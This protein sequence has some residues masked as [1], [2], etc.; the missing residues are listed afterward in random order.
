V[1]PIMVRKFTI[2]GR[3]AYSWMFPN[4]REIDPE[5][6][7][8]DDFSDMERIARESAARTPGKKAKMEIMKVLHQC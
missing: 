2:D 4:L 1:R 8:P 3:P 7:A 5:R 6:S